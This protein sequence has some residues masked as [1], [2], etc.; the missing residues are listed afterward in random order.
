MAGNDRFNDE[1]SNWDNN[2]SVQEATRLAFDTLQPILSQ[3]NDVLE[4]GCGTGLLTLRAA[5]LVNQIVAIDPAQGMIEMLQN[6]LTSPDAPDNIKPICLLLEDP[7]DKALPPANPA[8]PTGERKKFDLITSHLVL[9]HVPDV[10]AFLRTLLGC[11]KP[12]G[13]V[14]LTDFE[15]FGPAAI[16]FHPPS[17]LEG[18]ERHGIQREWIEGLLKKVG[19]EDVSVRVGWTMDKDVSEWKEEES[20]PF[21][22]LICEGRQ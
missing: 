17:K 2:P 22:F 18:V 3:S 12:G 4:V 10:E 19:F 16:K 11:L 14:A 21:P 7:E 1:A 5:P 20:L 6:K 13:R 15:D 9:H 8:N